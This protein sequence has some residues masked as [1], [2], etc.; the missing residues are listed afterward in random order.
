MFYTKLKYLLTNSSR[1]LS[2]AIFVMCVFSIQNA[3]ALGVANLTNPYQ[4]QSISNGIPCFSWNAA[5][6]AEKYTV[7]VSSDTNF[8]QY[9]KRWVLNDVVGT[10][11]CWNT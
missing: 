6:D 11:Q 9:S 7:Q 10:T 3:F 8:N 4:N 5:T 2:H 1:F